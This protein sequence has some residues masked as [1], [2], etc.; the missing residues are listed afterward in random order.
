L[1]GSVELAV[2]RLDSRVYLVV[3]C[4]DVDVVVVVSVA[5]KLVVGDLLVAGN[6]LVVDLELVVVTVSVFIDVK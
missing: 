6:L 4:V 5:S 3:N 1:V 2:V